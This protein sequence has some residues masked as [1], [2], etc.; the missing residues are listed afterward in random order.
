[1]FGIFAIS[2]C[3]TI[4]KANECILDENPEKMFEH[5]IAPADLLVIV[6]DSKPGSDWAQEFLW[7]K[8]RVYQR[9]NCNDP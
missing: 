5:V 3:K 8:C 1:V 7:Y 9:K 2:F 6:P 4:L